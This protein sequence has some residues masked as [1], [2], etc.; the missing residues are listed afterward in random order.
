[1]SNIPLQALSMIFASE[2]TDSNG[3]VLRTTSYKVLRL[4]WLHIPII[5]KRRAKILLVVVASMVTTP[6]LKR[7]AIFKVR[8]LLS[9]I[10]AIRLFLVGIMD[11]LCFRRIYCFLDLFDLIIFPEALVEEAR[12]RSI[13]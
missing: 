2:I 1:M 7:V 3:R 12:V 10:R 11:F 6:E 5:V 13:T 9:N 4:R 8:I